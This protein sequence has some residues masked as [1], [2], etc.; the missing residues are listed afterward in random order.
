ME[1]FSA[2]LGPNLRRARESRGFMQ[3]DL[4]LI[5]TVSQE[6]IS[7]I[8]TGAT[9]NP[10]LETILK[11]CEALGIDLTELVYGQA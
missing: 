9:S 3:V 5:T 2:D 7:K 10:K 8:E 6:T 1:K 4:A 11:L